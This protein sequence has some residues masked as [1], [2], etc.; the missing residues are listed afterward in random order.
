MP[1][2]QVGGLA[3]EALGEP[4]VG[5]LLPAREGVGGEPIALVERLE[6]PLL[7]HLGRRDRERE[8]V[9]I[10]EGAGC[11]V[12]EPRELAHVVGDR[13]ADRLRRLPGL[14]AL[15]LVLA[16]AEDPLDLVV[17]DGPTGDDAA[18]L[19]ERRLDLRLELDDP[20]PELGRHLVRQ[21]ACVE[22]L[23]LALA[24]APRRRSRVPP[25]SRGRGRGRR[26]RRRGRAPPRR[27]VAR[28]PRSRTTLASHQ[29]SD[30]A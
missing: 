27:G 1:G 28:A 11:P 9:P 20:V 22:Q 12:P 13:G 10:A 14:A 24:R 25:G 18:V 2:P 23:E 5:R 21:Q 4:R 16:L 8:P 26:A 17:V 15:A 7:V 3:A 29:A 6:E 30:D 19:G